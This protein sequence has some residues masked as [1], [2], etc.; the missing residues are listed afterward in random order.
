MNLAGH[1]QEMFFLK[2][3][4]ESITIIITDP[5]AVGRKTKLI[6]LPGLSMS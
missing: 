4:K 6:M 2:N 3:A 5:G 1:T